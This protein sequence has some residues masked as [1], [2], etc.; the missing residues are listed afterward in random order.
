MTVGMLD[1]DN[2]M[3]WD[4]F[5]D[6]LDFRRKASALVSYLQLEPHRLPAACPR[7]GSRDQFTAPFVALTDHGTWLVANTGRT[8]AATGYAL[9]DYVGRFLTERCSDRRTFPRGATVSVVH[10]IEEFRYLWLSANPVLEMSPIDVL[11]LR[12]WTDEVIVL[13]VLANALLAGG[14]PELAFELIVECL[15]LFPELLLRSD[16]AGHLEL[17]ALS[18][19]GRSFEM[20][21]SAGT[22]AQ[23]REAVLRALS[24]GRVLTGPFVEFDVN[25][26]RVLDVSGK[27]PDPSPLE[28]S[29]PPEVAS[30]KLTIVLLTWGS[31]LLRNLSPSQFEEPRR[32]LSLLG[33]SLKIRTPR[34]SPGEYSELDSFLY[35]RTGQHLSVG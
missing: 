35:Q 15:F 2:C 16:V 20:G 1:C 11:V 33:M 27:S 31:V 14:R 23:H 29:R 13:E 10:S 8:R 12:H 25:Y 34:L 30:L 17:V 18:G 26:S 32:F 28:Q 22:L 4:Y 9:V 5:D 21:D 6:T 24:S 7:C 19:G 3:T